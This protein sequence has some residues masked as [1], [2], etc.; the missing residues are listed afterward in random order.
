MEANHKK[1]LKAIVLELRHMLEGYYS[2][3][4]WHAGDLEQRLNALGVWRD[5]NPLPADELAGLSDADRDARKVVDAYLKLRDEAG[6]RREEAVAEFVRETA[7]TWANR[8]LALRCME[9]RDLIDEVILQKDVYSGRSLEH[10]RLAQRNPELCAGDDD[11]L[12]VV[13]GNAFTKQAESLPLLFDPKAPGI[14]LNPSVAAVKRSIALLSGTE[15]IRGQDS[16]TNNVFRASDAFGWA[17]QYWNTEEKDRVFEGVRTEK[18]TKIEGSDIIPATQLYTEPYMVKFLVQNSLGA[19]W[20]GMNPGTKLVDVWDYYVRNADHSPVER[21]RVQELTFL[22]PAC[23]SGHFLIEAFDL[24]Y[25]MYEEEGEI[26]DPE[27]ICRS[28]LERNLY[29]IDI[30]ERAIQI[31]EAALWMKAA[32]KAVENSGSVTFSVV[33]ANLVATNIRLPKGIDHLQAFLSEHPDDQKLSAALQVVFNGL[34]NADQLGSLLQIEVPVERKLKE[35]QQAEVQRPPIQTHLYKPTVSQEQLPFG[36]GSYDEWKERTV[37]RLRQHF[38]SEATNVEGGFFGRAASRGLRLFDLLSRRYDVVAAN[39]P[40]MGSSNLGEVVKDY[41]FSR[42][43]TGKADLYSAFI[44]RC[45]ELAG[46]G[47]RVAMVTQQSWMYLRSFA[48]LRCRESGEDGTFSGLVASNTLEV[49]MHLGPGA[50]HEIGGEVVNSVLF[51]L[52]TA[53]PTDGHRITAV[54]VTDIDDPDRKAE[55][56]RRAARSLESDRVYQPLQKVLLSIPD[57]PIVYQLTDDFANLLSAGEDLGSIAEVKP[58]PQTSDN[59]RFNRLFWEVPNAGSRWFPLSKGGGFR[60][61]KGLNYLVIDWQSDGLRIKEFNQR[62]GDHWSRNVRN[63]SFIFRQGITYSALSSAFSARV[64]SNNEICDTKGPGVYSEPAMRLPLLGYLNTRITQYILKLLS[65]ALDFSPRNIA[66]LPVPKRLV[67]E[68]LVQCIVDLKSM[69][70]A[71]DMVEYSFSGNLLNTEAQ[72]TISAVIC[73]AEA[74]IEN[75]SAQS[76]ALSE[77]ARKVVADQAGAPAGLLPL[78]EGYDALPVFSG[79]HL[80]DELYGFHS[81]LKRVRMSDVELTSLRQELIK[82]HVPPDAVVKADNF[83][84]E[85]KETSEETDFGFF[86]KSSIPRES[87]TEDLA[88]KF[89]INPVSVFWLARPADQS[90]QPKEP[91]FAEQPENVASLLILRVLGHRWPKE[92]SDGQVAPLSDGIALLSDSPSVGV[93]D[94]VTRAAEGDFERGF[95]DAVGM[96]FG[97][98]LT[99]QFFEDHTRRFRKRPVAWHFL[100]GTGSGRRK[101]ALQLLVYY[102]QVRDQTIPYIQSQFIRPQRQRNETE[103]RSIESLPANA[104]SDRQQERLT[105]LMDLI[106]ELRAFDQNLEDISRLG[107]GPEKMRQRLRQNAVDDA[108][109]CLKA[110]W[111]Q[112]LS[113][114]IKAGPLAPWCS[115]AD[116]T[117]LHQSLAKWIA[118]SMLQLPH[119]CSAVGPAAPKSETLE[120]DPTSVSLAFL[121]TKKPDEMVQDALNLGCMAWWRPLDETV[122]GPLRA[123][124]KLAKGELKALK[125]EDYS[126]ADDPFRRKKEIEAR[127][128]ELKENVKRWEQDLK[129]KTATANKLRDEIMAWEC[130]EARGWETWL[131]AQPMYDTISSL[132]GVRKAPRIVADWIAQESAYAPDIN[133][134]VRVNIAPLQKARILAADVLAAKDVDKAIADRA[135]WRADER[136]WCREGKLPQP[137]W[138]PMEKTNGSG[139][140]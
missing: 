83:E 56:L 22:D 131:A 139:Q 32:E 68:Q 29:G 99:R 137:G 51:V 114:T 111:L 120:D 82:A 58:G 49:L 63:V 20:A 52:S 53:S 128:K 91:L 86:L 25:A 57:T 17:Y 60:R 33:P 72:E 117:K 16:A 71:G 43:S 87:L 44:L 45:I 121:I 126:I 95:A 65:P 5:R 36:I 116:T 90:S 76:L 133:D 101:P 138:W 67:S 66:K 77:N 103:L 92:I 59:T 115:K 61:W 31:S 42:Y 125:A 35:L 23:G 132:D 18:G 104:R 73:L 50:F 107:F 118:D 136:R 4:D 74:Y 134:G 97:A 81:D 14:A 94:L 124:I 70:I 79:W 112:K 123:Q 26:T 130:S 1:I 46:T 129:E 105:E 69:L 106:A 9:S 19:T 122:F 11:G 8:L 108:T 41:I 37:A 140:K 64:L 54:S 113:S 135:E 55:V 3:S 80:P 127:T 102:G 78:V 109:L 7:Y 47:T 27:L 110:Q 28:V 98:W 40:Y 93:S 39:P 100:S 75:A 2:G 96:P 24:F 34:E 85:E 38:D 21:K 48:E 119:H 89:G 30:D 15:A 88:Y 12:F 84:G 13:L 6:V 62:S 10:N